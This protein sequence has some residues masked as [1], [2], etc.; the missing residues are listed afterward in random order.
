M[1][2]RNERAPGGGNRAEA[3]GKAKQGKHTTAERFPR[4]LTRVM[5]RWEPGTSGIVQ[6]TDWLAIVKRDRTLSATALRIAIDFQERVNGQTYDCYPSVPTIMSDTLMKRTQVLEGI[7]RLESRGWIIVDR[8]GKSN[9]YALSVCTEIAETLLKM[10]RWDRPN[11]P[12]SR[13][14]SVRNP[15]P[16]RSGKPD[17]NSARDSARDSA[18]ESAS[19]DSDDSD[20]DSREDLASHFIR[21]I[22]SQCPTWPVTID[23][24]A[25]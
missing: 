17:P 8:F 1:T 13:T 7:E 12:E 22:R 23:G 24:E 15:G 11:S 25:A 5:V 16:D 3:P 19:D 2:A 6:R 14:T 21:L 9:R 20:E 10:R 4:H 18:K